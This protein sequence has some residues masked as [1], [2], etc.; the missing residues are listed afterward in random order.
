MLSLIAFLHVFGVVVFLGNII[1]TFFWKFMADRT[2]SHS[3]V[4]FSQRLVTK[5]D[6]AFTAL[7]AGLLSVS[8]YSYARYLNY[9]VM[10]SWLFWAQIAF[11]ASA[12]IWAVVLLPIQHKQSKMAE[13]FSGQGEIPEEYWRLSRYWNTFGTVAI[14]LP[15]ISLFLMVAKP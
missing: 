9:D 13:S 8:G 6:R 5:T 15:V 12:A 2:Q 1:V 14:I 11:Y 3:V 10:S 4:A 7:G